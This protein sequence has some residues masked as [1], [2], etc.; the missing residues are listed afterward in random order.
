MGL[1]CLS[2]GSQKAIL[3]NEKQ[4]AACICIFLNGEYGHSDVYIGAP[5][6][7]NREGVRE[8]I[9]VQ[10][11]EIE[12]EQFAHSVKVLKRNDGSYSLNVKLL[13]A[14]TIVTSYIF[15]K[16]AGG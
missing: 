14:I 13:L 16:T 9:E 3:N 4:C 12:K 1:E 6:I 11:N 2:F 8:I 7:I 5:A 10:L 15:N